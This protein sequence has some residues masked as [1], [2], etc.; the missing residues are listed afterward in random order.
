M[1]DF[2][3]R[4]YPTASKPQLLVLSD[5]LPC[6]PNLRLLVI[7]VWQRRLTVTMQLAYY[8]AG[9][10]LFS[11][12]RS[13]CSAVHSFEYFARLRADSIS[14]AARWRAAQQSRNRRRARL[15]RHAMRWSSFNPC[16][17]SLPLGRSKAQALLGH[18]RRIVLELLQNVS[19]FTAQQGD[20]ALTVDSRQIHPNPQ[21]TRPNLTGRVIRF[22]AHCQQRSAP[23]C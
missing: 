11:R 9:A 20:I 23:R 17:S 10:F 15:S 6:R 1:N 12:P 19:C 22:S 3:R 4:S 5:G 7:R 8:A 2:S 13:I 14:P 21:L 18:M 16:L